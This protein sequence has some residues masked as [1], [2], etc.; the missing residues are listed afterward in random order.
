MVVAGY[1]N[2]HNPIEYP[3][4]EVSCVAILNRHISHGHNR[5]TQMYYLPN[6]PQ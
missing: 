4:A 6:A 2:E 5:P 3:L 1:P